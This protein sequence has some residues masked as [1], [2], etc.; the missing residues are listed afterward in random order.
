[1]AAAADDAYVSRRNSLIPEAERMADA[2]LATQ[3]PGMAAVMEI[4]VTCT[5]CGASFVPESARS[6]KERHSN[7]FVKKEHRNAG[8][9]NQRQISRDGGHHV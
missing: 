7:H 3:Y 2:I 1:M 8:N 9:E 5:Q 4:T 6:Q